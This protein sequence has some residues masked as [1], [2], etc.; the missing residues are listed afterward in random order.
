M[1]GRGRRPEIITPLRSGAAP[2]ISVLTQSL[3]PRLELAPDGGPGEKRL[4]IFADSRQD[5]AQQAG[6]LRDRYQIF[7]QRQVVYQE[8][9]SHESA[10]RGPIAL[11]D[12]ARTVFT[13]TRAAIGEV[14]AANLLSDVEY[15]ED[16]FFEPD[17]TISAMQT[18]QII[19][20][21]QWDLVVEFTERATSRFSLEREGLVTVIYDRLAEVAKVAIADFAQYGLSEEELTTLLRALLDQMR[22]RQAVNY[23]PFREF[24]EWKSTPMLN[25]EVRPTRETQRPF[26]FGTAKYHRPN[27]ATVYAWYIKGSSGAKRTAVFD[28]FARVMTQ[29]PPP[30][31]E[32]LLDQM[33][34][35]LAKRN[36]IS[37]ET[38]GRISV[39]KGKL[40]TKGYQVN[41]QLI[42]VTTHGERFRCPTCGQVRGYMLQ[43]PGGQSV[44]AT[45]RCPGQPARYT[46]SAQDSF[47]VSVYQASKIERLYPVE[48]SGQLSNED[49]VKFEGQFKSGR[50]NALVCTPTMELGVDIG[51]LSA[52]L[53]RNI[54]PTP[55]N[56]AQRAGRA[57]RKRR[58]ALILGHAGQGPHDSYF[59]LRPDE[60]ITGAIRPPLFMLDNQVVID[61][62]INSLILEKLTTAVPDEWAEIRTQEGLLREEVLTPFIQELD[63]RGD[64]IRH[65]V[66]AAFVRDRDAGGLPWLTPEYIDGRVA[67]FVGGLRAGLEHWCRRYRE[68]YKEWRKSRDKE[69]LPGKAQQEHEKRLI[70]SLFALENDRRYYPLS[71]LAQV[72][73]LP[74]YGFSGDIV[75][76]R[77]GKEKQ[78]SQSAA[79][80]ITEYAPGNIV[81]V[82]GRKV[83]VR[84]VYFRGGTREDPTANAATYRLCDRCSYATEDVLARDCPHCGESLRSD[85]FIDYEEGRGSV[86]E[87]ITQDDEYR[88]RE[89]YDVTTYLRDNDGQEADPQDRTI[90]YDR[91][92]V[93]Y[94]RRR[95]IELYN[96]GLRG[97]AGDIQTPFIICLECGCWHNARST[98]ASDIDAGISG[99]LPSCSVSSWDPEQSDRIINGL[100]LRAKIQGDV[101]EIKLPEAL[102]QN[103]DWI[104]TFAQ[105]LKLG[106]QRQ[107]YVGP[108]EIGWFISFTY[109][110]GR[111]HATLV[112]YDTMPGGT[113][114]LWRAAHSL[115]QLAALVAQHLRDCDCERACYRCLKE[116]WNQHNH[117]LLDKR[118]VLNTL[119]Q[120]AETRETTYLPPRTARRR[121]ESFLEERFAALLQAAELPL[122]NTQQVLR[123]ADGQYITRADFSYDQ[124]PLVIQTD[125]RAYHI[126]SVVHVVEDLDRRNTLELSGRTLL[127][128]TYRD[129]I[130]EPERVIELVRVVLQRGTASSR[131]LREAPAAYGA[132][133]PEAQAFLAQL[134]ARDPRMQPGGQLRL[135]DGVQLDLLAYD[136]NRGLAVV[137]VDPD[138]WVNAP[139]VWQQELRLHNQARVNGWGLVRVPLL[140]LGSNDD[141]VI[142]A[143]QQAKES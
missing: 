74:R 22:V 51:D 62:H 138:R 115:P 103:H 108:Q 136:L 100:H 83:Q 53:M 38:I 129:V 3:L 109:P 5:T 86:G 49:R 128:F 127:E 41:E 25:R 70:Q 123:T 112:L 116:F 15:L 55:S 61:R 131:Q 122:P 117:A 95:I 81:Y 32:K 12:L 96:R 125:G 23:G 101:I 126:D 107:L 21:L 98:A 6:Y 84:R 99:H 42:A 46:P 85:R 64:L 79:V 10:E 58:I 20:R 17:T 33:V 52:L 143:V 48:H 87:A 132:I 16:G 92:V 120:L 36:Y 105:A 135:D 37:E 69:G 19:K 54:P 124:P 93:E 76:L 29:L 88:S 137:L 102:A 130:A 56:Y 75:S 97:A 73:F 142:A 82:G 114:Y 141:A 50:I 106:M 91:W 7:T 140:W 2:A 119:D 1:S 57:G 133:P 26:G 65:A 71:Y 27:V 94:S 66:A 59:F 60:M 104:A 14:D 35:L 9:L 118:L 67:A 44:C 18:N 45:Y 8:L 4:L 78:L 110:G 68:I 90:V 28:L 77:Y 47:Y 63:R 34:A 134:V 121:F 139:K 39:A 40:S 111:P 30:K 43:M 24:L 89:S 13:S 31:V 80:G 113:G 72:G 11:P